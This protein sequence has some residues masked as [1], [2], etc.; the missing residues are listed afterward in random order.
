MSVPEPVAPDFGGLDTLLREMPAAERWPWL[1][2]RAWTSLVAFESTAGAGRADDVLDQALAD[3]DALP[4]SAPGRM[5]LAARLLAAHLHDQLLLADES[6]LPRA[7]AL[8]EI[9]ER[10][11]RP[12]RDT[13]A[14]CAAVRALGVAFTAKNGGADFKIDV[15]R[16]EIERLAGIVGGRRPYAALVEQTRVVLR[17]KENVQYNDIGEIVTMAGETAAAAGTG[18]PALLTRAE[19]MRAALEGQACA[20]RGDIGGAARIMERVSAMAGALRDTDPLRIQTQ[21]LG[22]IVGAIDAQVR[23]DPSGPERMRSV[24]AML[25]DPALPQDQRAMVLAVLGTGVLTAGSAAPTEVDTAVADLT[26][27]VGVVQPND[28]DRAVHL[29]NLGAARLMRYDTMLGPARHG[30]ADPD[31]LKTGI[32]LLEQARSLAGTTAHVL[33]TAATSPLARGYWLAGRYADARATALLGLRGH[34]WNVLLQQDPAAAAD[35]A[36]HAAEDAIEMARM[37]LTIGDAEFAAQML[38]A[39][40]GLVL[41]AATEL[42]GAAERLI[43][44]GEPDLAVRWREAVAVSG[45]ARVPVELRRRVVSAIAGVP[46]DGAGGVA[47]DLSGALGAGSARLLQ[48][49]SADEIRAALRALDLDALVYLVPADE[50]MGFT[51]VVPAIGPV[52]RL[53]LP[54]LGPPPAADLPTGGTGDSPRD[55]T[56]HRRRDDLGAVCDWAWQAAIGPVLHG[57]L[58]AR[59]PRP[60]RLVLVPM[61]QLSAVPWHAARRPAGGRM[62]YAVE[63]AVITYVASARLLCEVAGPRPPA[64]EAGGTGLFVGDPD[65]GI[66]DVAELKAAREEALT[67][68]SA[69]YPQARYLGRL[70]D[71]TASPAGAGTRP[72]VVDWLLDQT[73]GPVAH[74]ACHGVNRGG[75]NQ[76]ETSYLLLA[77]G[78][79]LSAESLLETLARRRGRPI[80]LVV[81]AACSSGVSTRGYDEAFS[82]AT[83]LLGGGV[84]SVVSTLWPVPDAPTS[85]L[86]YALH[87][88]LRRRSLRPADALNAAQRWMLG[89][90]PGAEPELD[91]AMPRNRGPEPGITEWAGFV[92]AGW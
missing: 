12:L 43:A 9:A 25:D 54:Q 4:R 26:A 53:L 56:A 39:G 40:R 3:F 34:A 79:R 68:R 13:R 60:V 50:G 19:L 77:G 72:Q 66:A 67:I 75:G 15:A 69:F 35:A 21:R 49:P 20:M 76:A 42:R 18:H 80:G 22:T 52:T 33:W 44:L 83:V 62:R 82:L 87:Y 10:D 37:G 85:V 1:F 16:A 41:Y 8:A 84:A 45:P 29:A 64:G 61:R 32:A 23:A 57:Y 5:K 86:M 65:T 14:L 63:D 38:D 2:T 81:L 7:L 30:L 51:V 24:R 31:D 59:R 48:P 78:E 47:A 70:P 92:H 27:A 88:F 55:M 58:A 28:P 17:F 46:V 6:R 11:P 90:W 89:Q 91:R 71:G 73:G 36:R 74:L